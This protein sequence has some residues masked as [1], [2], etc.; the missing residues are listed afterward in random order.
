M[1][2]LQDSAQ[3]PQGFA[4]TLFLLMQMARTIAMPKG[5]ANHLSPLS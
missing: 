1:V 5:N 3:N 4:L 2:I